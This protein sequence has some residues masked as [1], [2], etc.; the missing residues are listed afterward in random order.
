MKQK[1]KIIHLY[2][3]MYIIYMRECTLVTALFAI[4]HSNYNRKP[5]ILN[6]DIILTSK[7]LYI[8]I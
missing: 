6:N 4:I 7:I 8:Y 2:T 3:V 5:N 1:D